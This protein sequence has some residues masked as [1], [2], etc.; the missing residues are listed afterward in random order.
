MKPGEKYIIEIE[1]VSKMPKGDIAFIKGF[2]TLV[3]DGYGLAQLRRAEEISD[4]YKRGWDDAMNRFPKSAEEK[5]EIYQR[6]RNECAEKIQNIKDAA[7]K[8]G[9]SDAWDMIQTMYKDMT[10]G[11]LRRIFE[12]PDERPENTVMTIIVKF[13][14]FEVK[15]RIEAYEK[16]K[17]ENEKYAKEMRTIVP[18]DE[19]KF[20]LSDVTF[21]V[22]EVDGEFISGFSAD[23]SQFCDKRSCN[24]EKTGRH[25]DLSKLF[26]FMGGGDGA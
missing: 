21:L 1:S 14:V 25:F 24:W 3:F 26:Q 23:G 17:A 8:R 9:M 15:E 20:K 10:I 6:G 16:E 22:T 7:Y 4:A 19:V 2:R 11:E 18:G 13:P 12:M 5:H